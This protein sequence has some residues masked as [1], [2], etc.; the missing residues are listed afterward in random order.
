MS[1]YP[2]QLL[3]SASLQSL[4][5][6]KCLGTIVGLFLGVLVTGQF[7]SHSQRSLQS[8]LPQEQSAITLS[9]KVMRFSCVVYLGLAL[10]TAASYVATSRSAAKSRS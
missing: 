7:L 1:F 4:K 10:G 3:K 6:P 8:R 9:T 2:I 5:S